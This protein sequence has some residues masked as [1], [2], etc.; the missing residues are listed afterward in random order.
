MA[1]AFILSVIRKARMAVTE[2]RIARWT[3]LILVWGTGGKFLLK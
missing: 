2:Y 1:V 3:M